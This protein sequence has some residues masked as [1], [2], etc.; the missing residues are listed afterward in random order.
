M[1][2]QTATLKE[3]HK[4]HDAP[5]N[6]DS[7]NTKVGNRVKSL[8]EHRWRPVVDLKIWVIPGTVEKSIG[9][10]DSPEEAP[11]VRQTGIEDFSM[12]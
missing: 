7:C 10:H 5:F 8:Q 11:L 12:D 1:S 2:P 3:L 9:F 6:F 4:F